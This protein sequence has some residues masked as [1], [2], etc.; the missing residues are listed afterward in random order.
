MVYRPIIITDIRGFV[1]PMTTTVYTYCRISTAEVDYRYE[2]T[3]ISGTTILRC[4][5]GSFRIKYCYYYY[6]CLAKYDSSEA[7]NL[8]SRYVEKST[9]Y[10]EQK[11]ASYLKGV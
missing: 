10:S 9:K 6:M 1:L 7:V 5:G 8:C 3:Y 2:G 11:C 4:C